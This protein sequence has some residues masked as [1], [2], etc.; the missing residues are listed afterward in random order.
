MVK[1][2]SKTIDQLATELEVDPKIIN[3]L[4]TEYKLSPKGIRGAIGV[5]FAMKA[6]KRQRPKKQS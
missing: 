3:K 5:C 1:L 6:I 2:G 4:A